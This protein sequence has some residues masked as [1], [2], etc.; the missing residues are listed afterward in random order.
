VETQGPGCSESDPP[1]PVGEYAYTALGRERVFTYFSRKFEI[2]IAIIRLNY[3]NELRYGVLVDIARSVWNRE[4]VSLAMGCVNVIWQA[5]ANAYAL[6]AVPSATTPPFVLNVTGT[7]CLRVRDV[8]LKFGALFDR[9]PSFTG[10]ESPNALLNDSR[11]AH[12]RFGSP[13]LNAEQLIEWI[14]R[15]IRAGLP[16]WEKPTH[17]QVRDGRF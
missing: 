16:Q 17:F 9:P 7:E 5:D 14:A 12:R 2:P 8:A 1:D 11:L 15:W 10:V 6:A 13:R 4:P 3:A